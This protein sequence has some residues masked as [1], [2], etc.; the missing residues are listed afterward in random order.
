MSINI[1]ISNPLQFSGP[2]L[3]KY[4]TPPKTSGLY[5]I[6]SF[7]NGLLLKPN[8]WSVLYIGETGDLSDRGFPT[9]HHAYQRWIS[10]SGSSDNL[11]IAAYLTQFLTPAQRR[12]Y[13]QQLISE[14]QPPC[15]RTIKI[16]LFG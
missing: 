13:E 5:A 16:N 1:G 8:T 15:N 7:S 4:W 6:L 10:A 11:Y 9:S 2:S 14:Y 12:K 3:L